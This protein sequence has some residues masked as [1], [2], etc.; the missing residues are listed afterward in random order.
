MRTFI[1]NIEDLIMSDWTRIIKFTT[2]GFI[3]MHHDNYLTE[4]AKKFSEENPDLP[5][6]TTM[7]D[8]K[9]SCVVYLNNHDGG[10]LYYPNQNIVYKPV[11]GD[12]IV[13]D[14]VDLNTIHGAMP[15]KSKVRYIFTGTLYKKVHVFDKAPIIV[16]YQDYYN[17]MP[18]SKKNIDWNYFEK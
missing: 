10:E 1:P 2:G 9:Y 7:T 12:M 6:N 13:H 8:Q 16:S 3:A 5:R 15:L 14:S 11:A 4:Q 17:S 18:D